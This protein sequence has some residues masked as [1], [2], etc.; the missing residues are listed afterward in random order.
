V[1]DSAIIAER[2]DGPAL[3]AFWGADEPD[4]DFRLGTFEFDW[5]R[6]VRG[7]F[8]C[9]ESGLA[10]IR[11][12][13]GSWLLPP[14]FAGWIPP[15]VLHEVAVTGALSGWG[16]MLTPTASSIL[17]DEPC[18][19]GVSEL[20]R[21]L[22]RRAATW[23]H[24]DNL[25]PEQERIVAVLHDEIGRSQRHPL[26]LPLPSDQRL[27]R[28]TRFLTDNPDNTQS[29]ASLSQMAGLSERTARRLF[30]SETG[31]SFMQWRQQMR[32]ILSL[33]RLAGG[34]PVASVADALGYATTSAF[35][36]VFRKTFGQPPARYFKRR[37]TSQDKVY[38]RLVLSHNS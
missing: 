4:S 16:V 35:I 26:H 17:P 2:S 23:H 13:A 38:G 33:E 6:H 10:R 1:S 8:F 5:H 21:A 34:E 12:P 20:L 36:A 19:V 30:V 3:V 24:L 37:Q 7:Q 15:G 27:L 31:M 14:H 18:V 29:L 25:S 9:I 28:L 11:T 22:V 32:L